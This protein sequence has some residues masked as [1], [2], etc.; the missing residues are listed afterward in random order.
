MLAYVAQDDAGLQL[1]NIANPS[2]PQPLGSAD[3]PGFATAVAVAGGHAYVA[4]DDGGLQVID[5]S[6]PAAPQL[7]GGLATGGVA[8]DVA[9]GSG[10]VFVAETPSRLRVVEVSNPASPVIVATLTLPGLPASVLL[11]G[12][13][14][15]VGVFG[16]GVLVIDVWDLLVPRVIGGVGGLDVPLGLCAAGENVGVATASSGLTVIPAQCDA[17]SSVPPPAAPVPV[18]RLSAFPSPFAGT[19]VF[20]LDLPRSG[21]SGSR[22]TM[23]A[24]VRSARCSASRSPGPREVRWDGLDDSGRRLPAGVYWSRLRAGAG[25]AV[26]RVTMTR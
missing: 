4:D 15:Y 5:V 19:T 2:A 9:A 18:V 8:M 1:F 11:R 22:S 16:A 25:E 12:P 6:N 21:R 14:A 26:T 20:H 23:R 10:Y 7:V 3:T 17:A 13:T 24:D